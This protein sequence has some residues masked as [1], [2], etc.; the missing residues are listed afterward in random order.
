MKIKEALQLYYLRKVI[1]E[2]RFAANLERK[3]VKV[4]A[5][6][7]DSSSPYSGKSYMEC[8]RILKLP[9]NVEK[10]PIDWVRFL[11]TQRHLDK[12]CECLVEDKLPAFFEKLLCSTRNLS[13]QDIHGLAIAEGAWKKLGS[14]LASKVEY[15]GAF[16]LGSFG[17]WRPYTD[18]SSYGTFEVLSR[19]PW[20]HPEKHTVLQDVCYDSLVFETPEHKSFVNC[21]YEGVQGLWEPTEFRVSQGFCYVRFGTFLPLG[22]AFQKTFYEVKEEYVGKIRFSSTKGKCW[23]VD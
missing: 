4:Y 2:A 23:E 15:I 9:A 22:E 12:Y 1:V 11:N 10:V 16:F 14:D 21:F 18:Q 7:R 5:E 8:L 20:H 6:V 13:M 3:L 19:D 17:L